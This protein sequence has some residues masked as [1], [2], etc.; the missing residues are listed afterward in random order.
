MY[1]FNRK[2]KIMKNQ[3][4]FCIVIIFVILYRKK[5][6]TGRMAVIVI[7]IKSFISKEEEE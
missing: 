7:Y 4:V 6:K 1:V 5:D 2:N 3:C